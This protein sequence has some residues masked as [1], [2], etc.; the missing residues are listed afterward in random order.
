MKAEAVLPVA[1]NALHAHIAVV[2]ANGVIVAVNEPW[3]RFARD[4]K[5]PDPADGIGTNYLEVC[6]RASRKDRDVADM[7]VALREILS[8]RRDA[9]EHE[10]PCHFRNEQRWFR[11]QI[12]G[13]EE[14]GQRSAVIAHENIT[15]L[16]E[17][18]QE[19]ARQKA[20]V[21]EQLASA[22]ADLVKHTR[23]V[24]IGQVAASIAHELRNPLGAIRNATYLLRRKM[25]DP[26]EAVDRYLGIIEDEVAGSDQI[27]ADLM[28]MTRGKAPDLERVPARAAIEEVFKKI[29]NPDDVNLVVRF[30]RGDDAIIEVDRG[31]L[32]QVLTNLVS[33]AIQ[34][35]KGETAS[36]R[37]GPHPTDTVEV[38]VD[39]TDNAVEVRVSDTGPGIPAE[40][41]ERVF[42]PMF[43]TRT[44]GT[45]LGLAICRQIV[46]RHGGR[47]FFS[48][49]PSRLGGATAIVRLPAIRPSPDRPDTANAEAD[50]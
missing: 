41:L 18:E 17:A 50:P 13:Y 34:A 36:N 27:I 35:C 32:A 33:N 39:S 15:R 30:V 24:T 38:L 25:T 23:L 28:E 21:E 37:R 4:N 2:D 7:A 40:L 46:E 48:N 6:E 31:Q 42:E 26:D 49:E 14:H 29:G 45:G 43:S 19:L 16:K 47:I 11:V 10:Y 12:G 1:L 9:Y 3:R 22:R 20:V 5:F 8:G 44:K